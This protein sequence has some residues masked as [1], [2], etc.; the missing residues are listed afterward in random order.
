MPSLHHRACFIMSRRLQRQHA[1][2][3]ARLA[4]QR[5]LD[6]LDS[7]D[8][9]MWAQPVDEGFPVDEIDLNGDPDE[10][11]PLAPLRLVRSVGFYREHH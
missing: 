11:T 9:A 10:N 1:I 3:A 5:R 7:R 4:N 2:A 8:I 6:R